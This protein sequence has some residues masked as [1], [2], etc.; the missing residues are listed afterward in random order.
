MGSAAPVMEAA[1]SLQ[2]NR[3]RPPT[4]EVVANLRVGSRSASWAS[5]RQAFAA[6]FHV[7]RRRWM[8]NGSRGS[9]EAESSLRT[10]ISITSSIFRSLS[11]VEFAERRSFPAPPPAGPTPDITS[12]QGYKNDAPEG[13]G[14]PAPGKIPGSGGACGQDQ[15]GCGPVEASQSVFDVIQRAASLGR[16]VLEAAETGVSISVGHL[17]TAPS[18]ATFGTLARLSLARGLRPIIRAW[19]FRAMDRAS[20]CKAGAKRWRRPDMAMPSI[21]PMKRGFIPIV[22]A[23]PHR[24]LQSCLPLRFRSMEFATPAVDLS[25]RPSKCALCWHQPGPRRQI[26][27]AAISA[28]FR[29][30]APP[31]PPCPIFVHASMTATLP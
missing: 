18:T 11:T 21:L 29:T 16:I 25:L 9:S 17:V 7:R 23:A 13:I 2:R 5:Q 22:L 4:C 8:P 10:S 19:D 30:S 14:V 3:A 24:Q 12:R 31:W 27:Q 28:R 6:C 15:L 1:A 26:P 20:M